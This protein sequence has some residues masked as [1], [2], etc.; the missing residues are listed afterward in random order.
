MSTCVINAFIS[1]LP[2]SIIIGLVSSIM[3][4][5]LSG[6][7]R[8]NDSKNNWYLRK[9]KYGSAFKAWFRLFIPFTFFAFV[10]FSI[11][12]IIKCFY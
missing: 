1:V 3:W 6:V 4:G 9:L 7:G 2:A 5:P 8:S 12:Q 11:A 10:I